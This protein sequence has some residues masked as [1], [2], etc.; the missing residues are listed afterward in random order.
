MVMIAAVLLLFWCRDYLILRMSPLHRITFRLGLYTGVVLGTTTLLSMV[1]WRMG[2]SFVS[3][4]IWSL[5]VLVTVITLHIGG[6]ILCFWLRRS[7][8]Y[9]RVWL[10]ALIPTPVV[11]FFLGSGVM[12]PNFVARGLVVWLICATWITTMFAIVARAKRIEMLAEDLDFAVSL[13]GS[14]NCLGS[15]VLAVSPLLFQQIA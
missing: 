8:R 13:A 3:R 6:A 4:F 11:W 9:H 12:L 5:P 2:M 7:D 1:A 15:V 10:T 14:S